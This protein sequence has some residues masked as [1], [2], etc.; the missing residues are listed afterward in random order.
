MAAGQP[1]SSAGLALHS[2]TYFPILKHPNAPSHQIV[3]TNLPIDF[4]GKE[5]G[6]KREQFSNILKPKS[7][8]EKFQSFVES[9]P[10]KKI[11][12]KEG[13]PRVV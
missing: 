3:P 5:F 6:T 4:I 12:Y 8:V 11:Q 13:I 10:I 2:N 1:S 7:D 9:I